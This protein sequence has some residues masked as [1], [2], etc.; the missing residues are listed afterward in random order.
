MSPIQVRFLGTGTSQGIPMIACSCEVCSSEDPRDQRLRVSMHIE[1]DGKSFI[2]DT[3][4]DFRQQILRAGIRHVDAVLFTHE[5][6]DHTAGL[7]DIRGFNFAQ[8]TAIPLYARQQVI[9]QLKREFAYAFGENKYPGVPEIDVYEIDDKPFIV[10]GIEVIPILVKHYFLD[11]LGFR[12]GDFTYITDANFIA[13]EELAK[14]KGTKVLVIN[15]LRKTKHISHFTLDEALEV[16]EKIQPERAYITHISHMMGL[17]AE[18]Q[19]E[20]P[21][22]VF[23]AHDDLRLTI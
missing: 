19:R 8:Q 9:N 11:V 5:H 2:I 10:E 18:V 14:V 22:N 1:V 13:D 12:F 6:K 16:I 21:P 15:A 4:P 17:H 3:G 23:L 7:D 20:L